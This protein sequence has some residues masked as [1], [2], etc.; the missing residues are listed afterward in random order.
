MVP[1]VVTHERG[2]IHVFDAQTITRFWA[3][4][5]YTL[6]FLDNKEHLTEEPLSALAERLAPWGFLRVHRAEL[7]RVAAVQ[8]LSSA[9][10]IHEARLQDGQVARVSR[11]LMSVL[12][13]E[14][15]L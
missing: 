15:G 12:K 1:R 9:D 14:L 8:A 5:K 2:T 7:I 10:G 4:E 6:F 3:S 11:R 13:R